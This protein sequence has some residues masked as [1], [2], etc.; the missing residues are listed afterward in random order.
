M[1]ERL[2]KYIKLQDKKRSIFAASHEETAEIKGS[3]PRFNIKGL[4]WN[5]NKRDKKV[6]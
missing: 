6:I 3:K 1:K 2:Y 5:L 4:N